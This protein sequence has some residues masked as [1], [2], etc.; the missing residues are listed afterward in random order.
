MAAKVRRGTARLSEP[1]AVR[2][3]FVNPGEMRSVF[4]LRHTRW[5]KANGFDSERGARVLLLTPRPTAQDVGT[6]SILLV[7]RACWMG[8]WSYT[9]A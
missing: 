7:L 1:W 6:R 2:S 4:G 8:H 9:L 5:L 3:R